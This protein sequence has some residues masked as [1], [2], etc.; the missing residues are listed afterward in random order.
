MCAN[1]LMKKIDDWKQ[2][3]GPEDEKRLNDILKD[4]QKHRVAYRQ[5]KD[6][7]T[8]QLWAALLEL[9]K[10]NQR[11]TKKLEQ[12]QYIFDGMVERIKKKEQESKELKDSLET[13]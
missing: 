2:F 7:K 1:M 11:L 5:S 8:A 12:M 4:V 9:R 10:E 6:I 13:F 3:L